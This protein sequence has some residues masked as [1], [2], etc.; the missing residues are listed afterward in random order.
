[1]KLDRLYMHAADLGLD[2]QWQ[3][4][5]DRRRGHYLDDSSTIVLNQRLTRA[6]ATAT[7]AHEIGHAVFGDRCSSPSR[8]RR[9]DEYGASLLITVKDYQSAER[10]VGEH[11]GALAVELEVTPRLVEAWRRWYARK[12]TTRT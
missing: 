10:A 11:A 6:Q 1:V 4:L 7:L 3:D 2:V 12:S 5:G 9:A 8:E